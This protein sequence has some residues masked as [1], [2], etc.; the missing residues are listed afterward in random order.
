MRLRAPTAPANKTLPNHAG[1]SSGEV[2]RKHKSKAK[3]KHKQKSKSSKHAKSSKDK[4]EKKDKSKK[5]KHKKDKSKKRERAE[6]RSPDGRPSRLEFGSYGIIRESD[7]HLKRPEFA[8]W[9][10]EIK[11]IDIEAL[12]RFVPLL[13]VSA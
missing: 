12:P 8:S 3:D 9:A 10:S 6:D 5:D 4:K 7:Y 13:S 2:G 11:H 1:G